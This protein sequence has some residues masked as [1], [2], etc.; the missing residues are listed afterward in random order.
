MATKRWTPA[1]VVDRDLRSR[2]DVRPLRISRQSGNDFWGE[3]RG[4]ILTRRPHG[5]LEQFYISGQGRSSLQ[6]IEGP[7]IDGC[8]AVTALA[9][10]DE[11]GIR[12]LQLRFTALKPV[13]PPRSS[14][15]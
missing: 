9:E 2:I 6:S 12:V 13:E 1:M 4:G 8:P 15:W 5:H 3:G 7:S 10:A 11:C 14:R